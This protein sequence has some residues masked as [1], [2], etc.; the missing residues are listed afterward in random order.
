MS[1]QSG[2]NWLLF[3][4]VLQCV[5]TVFAIPHV[6]SIVVAVAGIIA[7]FAAHRRSFTGFVGVL[8]VCAVAAASH[9]YA[10]LVWEPGGAV[11]EGGWLRPAVIVALMLALISARREF[12]KRSR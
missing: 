11:M 8:A 4:F 2:V 7:A 9:V 12:T 5:V 1:R 3:M 6:P 10:L